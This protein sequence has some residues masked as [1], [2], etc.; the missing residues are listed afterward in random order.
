MVLIGLLS[1]WLLIHRSCL[2]L[3]SPGS[4]LTQSLPLVFVCLGDQGCSVLSWLDR[5][6]S[7][8]MHHNHH[9]Y[10]SV[11]QVLYVTLLTV[12]PTCNCTPYMLSSLALKANISS[13]L[14][15]L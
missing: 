1:E 10:M 3:C 9:V 8:Y 15:L 6:S 11:K 2:Q 14:Y 4:A 13:C 12:N 7:P 5:H